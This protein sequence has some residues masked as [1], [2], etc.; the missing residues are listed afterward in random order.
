MLDV[1]QVLIIQICSLQ[2][3]GLWLETE[4][5]RSQFVIWPLAFPVWWGDMNEFHCGT[6]LWEWI[7]ETGKKTNTTGIYLCVK[8][9]ATMHQSQNNTS[10]H[11]KVAWIGN[12]TALKQKM[13][14]QWVEID[15]DC[16]MFCHILLQVNCVG[17][18]STTMLT[19]VIVI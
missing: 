19:E 1:R 16:N 17:M 12:K 7:F 4:N 18:G 15:S 8:T 5:T 9:H 11:E 13:K 14:S 2:L 10:K 6:F 3:T